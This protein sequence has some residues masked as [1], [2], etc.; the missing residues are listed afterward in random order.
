MFNIAEV[1]LSSA[2]LGSVPVSLLYFRITALSHFV[3]GEETQH[4]SR[5]NKK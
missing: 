5:K 3:F 1:P 4:I 2:I